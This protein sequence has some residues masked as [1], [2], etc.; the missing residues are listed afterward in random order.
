M[1]AHARES[2][3]LFIDATRYKPPGMVQIIIIMF[4]DVIYKEKILGMYVYCFL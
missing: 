3:W 4:K 1:I 2:D